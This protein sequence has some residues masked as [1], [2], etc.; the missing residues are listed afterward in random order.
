MSV[1]QLPSVVLPDTITPEMARAHNVAVEECPEPFEPVCTSFQRD[2]DPK[3]H[4]KG[5]AIDYDAVGE[6]AF[7]NALGKAWAARV[8]ARLGADYDV[9][10]HRVPGRGGDHLHIE[11]EGRREA[12]YSGG[13]YSRVTDSRRPARRGERT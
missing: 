9:L 13:F 11:F 6:E 8:Q 10:W 4:G 3:L 7:P 5:L 12:P 2:H 1:D